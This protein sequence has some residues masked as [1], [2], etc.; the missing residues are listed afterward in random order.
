MIYKVSKK[1]GGRFNNL[2]K[3]RKHLITISIFEILFYRVIMSAKFN[4]L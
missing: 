1:I 4:K 3:I 2:I